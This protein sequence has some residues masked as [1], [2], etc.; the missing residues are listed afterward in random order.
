MRLFHTNRTMTSLES[1]E[2]R[3]VIVDGVNKTVFEKC[4]CLGREGTTCT[5][6]CLFSWCSQRRPSKEALLTPFLALV[7]SPHGQLIEKLWRGNKSRTN[8][9]MHCTAMFTELQDL[10]Q[11]GIQ[12]KPPNRTEEQFNVIVFYVADLS[13]M[14]KVLN[15]TSCTSKYCCWR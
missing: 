8:L 15:C 10:V 1:K 4:L 14:E 2:V 5:F 3:T 6:V 13:Q 7:S 9:N 11:C 12:L